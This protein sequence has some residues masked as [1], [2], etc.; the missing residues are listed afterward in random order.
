MI[1]VCVLFFGGNQFYFLV[2]T[3]KPNRSHAWVFIFGDTLIFLF[4]GFT[5]HLFRLE[6]QPLTFGRSHAG[7]YDKGCVSKYAFCV[8]A[9]LGVLQRETNLFWGS[10]IQRQ[11]RSS[12]TPTGYLKSPSPANKAT[13]PLDLKHFFTDTS[14]LLGQRLHPASLHLGG[15]Q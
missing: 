3:E 7:P 13:C 12:E 4:W 15:R 8:A 6:G 2:L 5:H 10:S 14:N 9:F 1:C 11:A